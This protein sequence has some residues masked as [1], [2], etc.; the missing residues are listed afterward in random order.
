MTSYVYRGNEKDAFVE[1]LQ[2]RHIAGQM[3]TIYWGT[4]V[5]EPS[6]RPVR[7]R[8]DSLD[9]VDLYT[10][11]VGVTGG[12]TSSLIQT[13]RFSDGDNYAMVLDANAVPFEPIEYDYDYFN[14]NPGYLDHILSS[15]N[16]ELRVKIAVGDYNLRGAV[17]RKPMMSEDDYMMIREWGTG[18]DLPGTGSRSRFAD[19]AEWA[20]PQE[21]VPINGAI[22]GVVSFQTPLD[23]RVSYTRD[24]D[25]IPKDA[26]PYE[27][28]L[29]EVYET[30]R[31]PLPPWV[32]FYLL[33]LSNFDGHKR[34]NGGW[35]PDDIAAAYRDDG[36]LEPAQVP[37]RFRGVAE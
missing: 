18:T 12:V 2:Q 7:E 22:E 33:V 31:E 34:A 9:W 11:E 23:I 8:L 36:R 24:K 25:M 14:E 26:P 5:T 35:R 3:H 4:L 37:A 6:D 13:K 10:T 30:Y 20:A 29:D 17:T 32:D 27:E 15:A 28:I 1:E 19:E 16:G 21:S